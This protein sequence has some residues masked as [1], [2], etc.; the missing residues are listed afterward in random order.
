MKGIS[1]ITCFVVTFFMSMDVNAQMLDNSKGEAFTDAPFFH[2]DFIKKNN[3]K[4][5]SGTYTH[6]KVGDI[7]RES[8]LIHVYEFDTLGRIS[9]TF[10]TI[11]AKNGFDTLVTIYE[12]ND[13]GLLTA[14]RKSDQYGFY[15]YH[16]EYDE[17]GRPTR[18]EFRR[19]L[20]KNES[21][22]DFELSKEFTV[23][24]ET[25]SYENYDGQEKRTF[26]N[27][28]DQPYR[29]EIT[30]TDKDGFVTEKVDRLQRTSGIK[31]TTY[32]YNGNGWLD[33]LR[34]ES[35]QAGK[36]SR[37]YGF[38]YDDYANLTSKQV[39]KNGIHQTEFQVIYDNETMLL[40]YILTRE[41]STNYIT[42]LKLD[43]YEFR[44][45]EK[46]DLSPAASNSENSTDNN[47]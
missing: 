38:E 21:R 26:Y 37:T 16:Y 46:I 30:Y 42:I 44:D 41:I 28:Y 36:V 40:N 31:K 27:S 8:E 35:N 9:M 29:D 15:A 19:N 47:N 3:I 7:I 18:E 23:Y 43:K 14:L 12:Y 1:L 24:Y 25:S 45:N 17:K 34:I 4:R 33:T 32:S 13:A 5:I 11:E 22:I 20:N 6:K 39:Y 2:A 10:E